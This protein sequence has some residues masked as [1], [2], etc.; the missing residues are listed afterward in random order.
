VDALTFGC[1]EKEAEDLVVTVAGSASEPPSIL[2][3]ADDD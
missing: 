1:D 2:V 3:D